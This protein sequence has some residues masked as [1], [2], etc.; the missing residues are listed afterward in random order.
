MIHIVNNI[1][2]DEKQLK[3]LKAC[4]RIN[5]S[6]EQFEEPENPTFTDK[7]AKAIAPFLGNSDRKS[8][9]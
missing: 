8:V 5:C 9:V 7:L 3:I 4:L 6:N 2:L 1:N